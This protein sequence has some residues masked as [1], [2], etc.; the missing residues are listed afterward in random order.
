MSTAAREEGN[1]VKTSAKYAVRA[2]IG[3][4]AAFFAAAPV[5][6]KSEPSCQDRYGHFGY[7]YAYCEHDL[8]GRSSPAERF[9]GQG[10][11]L[12]WRDLGPVAQLENSEPVTPE[13]T[14]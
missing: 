9:Q 7:S 4:S 14:V 6:A 8:Y 5:A 10:R 13:L 2:F 12:E 11:E 3:L 1:A